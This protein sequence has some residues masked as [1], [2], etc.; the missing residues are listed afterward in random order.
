MSSGEFVYGEG[1]IASF[2][3]NKAA[4]VERLRQAD[5][6]VLVCADWADE[7][8]L[9]LNLTCSSGTSRMEAV[10]FLSLANRE[11]AKLLA[12]AITDEREAMAGS[13]PV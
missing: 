11:V 5:S 13:D 6:Y 4:T 8:L 3:Q 1:A 10:P 9:D 2:D 7:E 12:K